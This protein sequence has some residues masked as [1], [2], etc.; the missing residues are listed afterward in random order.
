RWTSL[1]SPVGHLLKQVPASPNVE[2]TLG[3][4]GAP[5]PW[6]NGETGHPEIV[7][8]PKHS[9]G[10]RGATVSVKLRFPP[11]STLR[12]Q[13]QASA[14]A[15][16]PPH[17]LMHQVGPL[18]D[19]DQV[20]DYFEQVCGAQVLIIILLKDLDRVREDRLGPGVETSRINSAG[21]VNLRL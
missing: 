19:A 18:A 16:K 14:G 10:Q 4:P 8:T 7:E 11:G 15:V 2:G 5:S 9:P 3:R 13:C 20:D 1:E 17:L 6:G 12:T 21:S